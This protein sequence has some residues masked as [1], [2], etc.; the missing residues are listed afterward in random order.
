VKGMFIFLAVL[1]F[2]GRSFSQDVV[3]D[4]ATK[5]TW[6]DFLG[7]ADQKSPFAAM[8]SSGI[9]YRLKTNSDGYSDSVVAVFYKSD[10]WVRR[11]T[12]SA[13]IHEQ[14]HFDITEIFARKLRKQLEEFVPKRGDLGHQLKFLYDEVE[15]EREAM[16]NLYDKDTRHSADAAR[17]A[18]WN[19]R[20]SNELK[21]LEKYVE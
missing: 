16:E 19:M 13:L 15:S 17:Q 9:Y 14:G 6:A 11:R 20:I 21:E 4:S 1:F 2:F 18:D 10:S 12:E 3:W 8:T 7:K 5:L